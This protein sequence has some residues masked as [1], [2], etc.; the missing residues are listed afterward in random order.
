M[1][2][3]GNGDD[4]STYM[5][6]YIDRIRY[7]VHEPVSHVA[8]AVVDKRGQLIQTSLHK[9]D[10]DEV[11]SRKWEVEAS[12]VPTSVSLDAII[13]LWFYPGGSAILEI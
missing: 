5:N 4:A 11:G 9:N 3:N 6:M 1:V 10:S 2:R 7:S 8:P 13:I 12:A